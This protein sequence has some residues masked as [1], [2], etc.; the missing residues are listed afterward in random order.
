MALPLKI[1]EMIRGRTPEIEC[2]TNE[3]LK[4]HTSLK[5]GGPVSALLMPNSAREMA[6]LCSMLRE[7]DITPVIIGNG[8]NLLAE[9]GALDIIVV[10]TTRLNA[11]QRV[12]ETDIT[13]DS[14]VSLSRLATLARD[15]GLTGLEFAHG[16]P[17]TLGGA[18]L[19]NAGAYGGD[20]GGVVRKTTVFSY[21]AGIFEQ[22]G[23]ELGFSYRRSRFSDGKDVILTSTIKL[24]PGDRAEIT[25]R[26]DDFD[27]R[28][29]ESQPLELPSAG[30]AFKRPERGYAAALIE[31]AGLKGY[32]VG[33]AQISAKHSGF[34]V[35]RGGASYDDVA[36]LISHVQ[37]T[38]FK[39]SGIELEPEIRFIKGSAV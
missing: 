23:A 6:S 25:A 18:V 22:E 10:K 8:T 14:G 35:N 34:I 2:L 38:V 1:I 26:M 4:N 12:G 36:A 32:T 3:P 27:S 37:E 28:R 13:A 39:Q 24:A 9:D 16:I 33:G 21:E 19:M 5:I 7:F 29:R 15:N 20:I 30:S 31:Q 17:G 11:A